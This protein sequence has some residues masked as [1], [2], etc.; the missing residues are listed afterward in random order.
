MVD[1]LLLC[2]R[3]AKLVPDDDEA[4]VGYRWRL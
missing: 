2:L 4:H 1:S 3:N